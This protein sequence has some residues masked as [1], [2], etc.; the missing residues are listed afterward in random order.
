M[1][2]LP[3]HRVEIAAILHGASVAK[4]GHCLCACELTDRQDRQ[5]VRQGHSDR[6]GPLPHNSNQRIV[7]VI[8][9]QRVAGGGGR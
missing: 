6:S 9:R 3:A 8:L 4:V 5:V 2:C 7:V 1:S